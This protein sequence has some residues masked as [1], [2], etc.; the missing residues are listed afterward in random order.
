MG[1]TDRW[2]TIHIIS[3]AVPG[4]GGKSLFFLTIDGRQRCFPARLFWRSPPHK[5]S[6]FFFHK[7]VATNAQFFGSVYFSTYC[8]RTSRR[9]QITTW[10]HWRERNS[11]LHHQLKESVVVHHMSIVAM[12]R[13]CLCFTPRKL[14]DLVA[15][16][17]SPTL[18]QFSPI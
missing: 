18:L 15:Q 8:F 2:A 10:A 13:F 17:V 5:T 6:S 4:T 1:I 14:L 12:Y 7:R 9:A 3:I 11:S 16:T